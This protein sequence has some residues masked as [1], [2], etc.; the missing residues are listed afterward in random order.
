VKE[1][2]ESGSLCRVKGKEKKEQKRVK[3]KKKGR[4]GKE[5][6]H[7]LFKFTLTR[8]EGNSGRRN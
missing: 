8:E 3:T 7:L 2:R 1:R 4:K 6:H 5:L